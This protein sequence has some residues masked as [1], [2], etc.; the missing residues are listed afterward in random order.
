MLILLPALEG[1]T[2][3][4]M[5]MQ[6]AHDEY[7][8]GLDEVDEPI[9]PND[10]LAEMSQLWITQPVAA[11]WEFG[12]GFGGVDHE[13]R[14]GTGIGVGVL[15]DE[16]YGSLEVVSGGL[17]PGYL[18]SHFERRFLTCSWER[19]RPAAAASTPR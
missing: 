8:F 3:A 7:P 4:A 10:Q 19:T 2:K 14:K 13:L 11:V 6:D 5:P 1:T 18:S 17:G 15:G 9:G 12:Q 16:L